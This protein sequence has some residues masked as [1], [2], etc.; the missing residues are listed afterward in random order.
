MLEPE[1]ISSQKKVEV[2]ARLEEPIAVTVNEP[3]E[4]T[5]DD[6]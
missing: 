1:K 6:H 4:M 5:A 2:A 3:V